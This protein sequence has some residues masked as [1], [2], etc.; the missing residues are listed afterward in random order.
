M[1][2]AMDKDYLKAVA[3]SYRDPRGR[4]YEKDDGRIFRAIHHLGLGDY[5]HTLACGFYQYAEAQRWLV[6]SNIATDA[7]SIAAFPDAML[8]LEHERVPF[9]SYPYEWTFAQLKDAALLHLDIH[10]SAL[11]H[12]TTLLDSSAYNIQFLGSNPIFIDYL[13][14]VP[15]LPGSLWIGH[16]QF[17]EQ[18]LNPLLLYAKAGIEFQSWY[19]GSGNGI[20]TQDAYRILPLSKFFSIQTL[21]HVVAKHFLDQQAKR[22]QIFVE[23]TQTAILRKSNLSEKSLVSMLQNLRKFINDLKPQKDR[24][25]WESY[26]KHNT[27]NNTDYA[28]KHQFVQE[29]CRQWKP[30][31]LVDLGGNTGEFSEAALDAGAQEVVLVDSDHGALTLAYKRAI[32]RSL[33]LLPLLSNILDP[34][35]AQGWRNLERISLEQRLRSWQPDALLALALIH[36]LVLGGN[37]PLEQVINWLLSLSPRGI[38]EFVPKTDPTVQVMLRFK[39]DIFPDYSLECFQSL[40]SSQKSIIN[41]KPL[42]GGRM[43]FAYE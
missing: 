4:V 23:P 17:C 29:F 31:R 1:M 41:Q 34:S 43:L 39:Q 20:H 6:R 35:P 37:A 8:L 13:S 38:I 15:Y 28:A 21:L 36:H 16:H 19:R 25:L 26:A 11:Q 12:K 24:T 32:E 9:I 18:F 14:F 10:L 33:N 2:K 30:L 40:L 7:E 27:Y 5:Q 42:T 22:Q 3:A